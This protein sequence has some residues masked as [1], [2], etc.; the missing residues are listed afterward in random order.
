MAKRSFYDSFFLYACDTFILKCVIMWILN[1]S[2][3]NSCLSTRVQDQ[4]I[5]GSEVRL[6]SRVSMRTED[7]GCVIEVVT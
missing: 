4:K 6:W 1:E 3:D 5:L 2:Y 7:T